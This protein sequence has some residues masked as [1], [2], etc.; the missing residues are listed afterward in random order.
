[1]L[2]M[3]YCFFSQLCTYH[4]LN[5]LGPPRAPLVWPLL[6][7]PHAPHLSVFFFSH[8]G[9]CPLSSLSLPLFHWFVNTNSAILMNYNM[10]HLL[11]KRESQL[12][13][14]MFI[15]VFSNY[16]KLIMAKEDIFIFFPRI[17]CSLSSFLLTCGRWFP[18][19]VTNRPSIPFLSPAKIKLS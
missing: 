16:H 13:S 1:M 4:S 18:H 3:L 11:F 7:S 14:C 17:S 5:P 9:L 10:T 12:V 8:T 15:C 6:N 2:L 19:S